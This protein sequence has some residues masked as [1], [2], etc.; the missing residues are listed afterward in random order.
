MAH[1]PNQG[2]RVRSRVNF[3]RM[4]EL[5][6]RDASWTVSG[7]GDHTLAYWSEDHAGNQETAHTASFHID[8]TPPAVQ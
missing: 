2:Y 8:T 3:P 5:F 1:W 4:R 6:F 7:D